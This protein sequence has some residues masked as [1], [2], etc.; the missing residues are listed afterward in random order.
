MPKVL[1][2]NGSKAGEKRV[3]AKKPATV[4]EEN[5]E[6]LYPDPKVRLYLG[7]KALTAEDAKQL[8]GWQEETD[9]IKFDNSY[10]YE[11]RSI[12]SRKIRLFNNIRNRPITTSNLLTLRQEILR[13]RWRLNLENRIIGK[14]GLVFNGQHTLLAL[15]SAV[16]EW[17]KSPED[18]PVWKTEP[19]I[20][21]SIAYGVEESDEVVNT[22]DT[23]KP[24]SLAEVLARSPYFAAM[25]PKGRIS[26]SRILSYAIKLLW[27]RAGG[28]LGAFAPRR[29]HSESLDFLERHP[30][31]LEATKHIYEEDTEGK[32]SRY[33]SPGYAAGLL[34]LMGSV[35][36]D[37]KAY[38]DND[39]PVEASLDW[40]L[41]EKACEFFVLLAADG[42]ALQPLK[43]RYIELREN[44]EPSVQEKT[45]LLI[46]AWDSWSV[47]KEISE[48]SLRLQYIQDEEEGTSRLAEM[49][50][51]GG[52]DLGDPSERDEELIDTPDPTPEEI[53]QRKLL[54][55][56]PKKNTTPKYSAPSR[57]GA[58]WKKDDVAWV[59]DKDDPPYLAQLMEDPY[60]VDGG[61]QRVI[62]RAPDGEWEV[63]VDNLSLQKPADPMAKR[64]VM[65]K[66]APPAKHQKLLN[67][68][69]LVIGSLKWV[70]PE[71]GEPWRGKILEINVKAKCARVL[72]TVGFQ[73]A[74]NTVVVPLTQLRDSQPRVA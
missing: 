45:A 7:E 59:E 56:K 51:L 28:D 39:P 31:L 15:I 52:I 53:E 12:F 6:V 14:T 71:K 40:S 57:K 72:V 23:C 63:E 62:V 26:C 11:I 44:G 16:E 54:I 37:P 46:T 47:G 58:E 41:W 33:V 65:P 69:N 32:I 25:T 21:T 70:Q 5:R 20:E 30:K 38:R 4:D 73:G 36:S 61:G 60:E 2:R 1:K 34:Y 55:K 22:M 67:P 42:E 18:F 74:G 10:C 29:T 17:R 66:A 64:P 24:R 27:S 35:K 49:P 3:S 48:K 68:K 9:K 19:T 43:D 50:I 8:L 13:G